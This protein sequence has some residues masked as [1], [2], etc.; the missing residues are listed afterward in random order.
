MPKAEDQPIRLN[1]IY[2]ISN[3]EVKKTFCAGVFI[4]QNSSEKWMKD[5][6]A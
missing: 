2:F 6:N 3:N 5:V 4:Q 1:L